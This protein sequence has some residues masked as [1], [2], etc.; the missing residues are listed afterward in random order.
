MVQD[1]PFGGVKASGFGRLNGR[2]GL[3]GM[4]NVKA[5][6]EDRLPMHQP[7]RLFPVGRADYGTYAAAI[8]TLYRPGVVGKLRAAAAL[9]G[10]WW[11][12]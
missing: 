11:K 7:T 1:L 4:C 12:G 6:V 3:H 8:Q 9:V 10:A 5:V 2:A